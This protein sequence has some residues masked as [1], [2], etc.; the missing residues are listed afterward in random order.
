MKRFAMQFNDYEAGRKVEIEEY[1]F[2]AYWE[3][4]E[5]FRSFSRA[6]G[7]TEETI[8]AWTN[9]MYDSVPGVD[10]SGDDEVH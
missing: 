10:E 1:D 6:L 9:S 8:N 3:L 5:Q 2:D 7:Y 4:V